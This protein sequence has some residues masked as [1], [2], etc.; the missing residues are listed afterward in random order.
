MEFGWTDEEQAF[1]TEVQTFI[2]QNWNVGT[3]HDWE[4]TTNHEATA[5]YQQALADHGWL[6]MAWPAEYGGKDASYIQQVV[7]NEESVLAGSP[8]G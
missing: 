8:R 1:R 3:G 4:P 6:T 2:N 5:K 7:F